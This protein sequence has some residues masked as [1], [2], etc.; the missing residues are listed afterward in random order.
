MRRSTLGPSWSSG[1]S[2]A[3]WL[4]L[5]WKGSGE[6]SNYPAS[7]VPRACGQTSPEPACP[8]EHTL[9][10]IRGETKIG[11]FHLPVLPL[12]H[13]AALKKKK[14]FSRLISLHRTPPPTLRTSENPRIVG[15]GASLSLGPLACRGLITPISG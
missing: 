6:S 12:T 5:Y 15:G 7:S 9:D 3:F 4:H 10:G 13:F 8:P 2:L 1:S 14:F 11:L